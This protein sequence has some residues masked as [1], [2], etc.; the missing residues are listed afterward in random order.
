MRKFGPKIS[1]DQSVITAYAPTFKEGDLRVALY[2]DSLCLQRE[3]RVMRKVSDTDFELV[4]EGDYRGR[5]Y[6]FLV[7]KGRDILEIADPFAIASSAN[8]LRSALVDL[9]RTDPEGFR[10]QTYETVTDPTS[11]ILYELHVRDFTVHHTSGA[12]HKGL[13]LGLAEGGTHLEGVKTGI[14]H[15][16]ELGIT[17]VHLLPVFDFGSVNERDQKGY[18]WGYDPELYNVPEGSYATDPDDPQARIRELKTMIAAFHERGIGVVMDVVYNHTYRSQHSPI[19]VLD[20]GGF[21]RMRDNGSFSNGSGCGNELA[22]EKERVRT[23]IIDS[24]LFWMREYRVDGFRFDLMGLT[25][26]ETMY[27]IEKALKEENPNVLLYGEPWVGGETILPQDRIFYKGKQ[28][29]HAIAVFNDHFRDAI[30]G[31]TNGSSWG[32]IQ[33][34][35][36]ELHRIQRGLVGEVNFAG[37]LDGFAKEPSEVINYFAAH[38]N[39]ILQ[40][41]LYKSLPNQTMR[42]YDRLSRLAF[43]LLLTAQGVPFIHEGTEFMRDKKGVHNSYNSPDAIN[44]IDWQKKVDHTAFFNYVCGLIALR[45]KYRHFRLAT[46]SEIRKKVHLKTLYPGVLRLV[47][48]EDPRSIEVVFNFSGSGVELETCAF[49]ELLAD[50]SGVYLDR[51]RTLDVDKYYLKAKEAVV[52]MHREEACK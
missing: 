52:I 30:K 23:F 29:G 1:K 27:A 46:S 21:Y 50:L 8:S 20:P 12:Q 51:K 7:R 11:R 9:E 40:D 15:L 31:D 2:R 24:L 13:Y 41:K 5:F 34:N 10:E 3:V 33:G 48:E 39:L 43:L 36:N 44:A 19:N 38:D 47:I 18:N 26:V 37:D 35:L 17:H 42:D 28:K 16:V 49:N 32:V 14:D 22:S 6:T 25:D 4:L 45:G